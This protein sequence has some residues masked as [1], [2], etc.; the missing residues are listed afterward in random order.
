MC[1]RATRRERR[2]R[3]GAQLPLVECIGKRHGFTNMT[4]PN[5]LRMQLP[6]RMVGNICNRGSAQATREKNQSLIKP[7]CYQCWCKA[8]ATTAL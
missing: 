1:R 3:T 4:L 2:P 7:L 5:V 8:F 6:R